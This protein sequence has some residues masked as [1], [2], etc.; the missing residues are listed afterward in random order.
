M[1]VSTTIGVLA[2][3]TLSSIVQG[4][5]VSLVQPIVLTLGAAFSALDIDAAPVID[6]NWLGW[7]K[8]NGIR[9]EKA[10][11]HST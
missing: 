9:E 7:L 11:A 6:V 2:L 4:S 10:R 3:L 1:K 8:L 5:W